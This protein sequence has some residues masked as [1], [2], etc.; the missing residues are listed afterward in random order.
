MGW[1]IVFTTEVVESPQLS[2]LDHLIDPAVPNCLLLGDGLRRLSQGLGRHLHEGDRQNLAVVVKTH[3]VENPC[4]HPE[5]LLSRP[6]FEEV[7]KALSF[8]K[9]A[10]EN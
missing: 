1:E 7:V 10:T 2:G 8:P 4:W 6:S 3:C 9:T 5:T